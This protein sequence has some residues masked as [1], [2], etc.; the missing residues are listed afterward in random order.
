MIDRFFDC[1]VLPT[2]SDVV[3]VGLHSW[4]EMND[5]ETP[6]L[7]T[8]LCNEA[9][10]NAR[11]DAMEADLKRCRKK[12]IARINSVNARQKGRPS[13]PISRRGPKG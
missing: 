8:Y 12:A 4:I 5:N 13:K 1:Y 10:V 11:F 2:D 6:M 3:F 7:G 9:E